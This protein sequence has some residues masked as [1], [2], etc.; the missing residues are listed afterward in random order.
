[1]LRK[2]WLLFFIMACMLLVGCNKENKSINIDIN[3]VSKSL[4]ENIEFKD[5]LELLDSEI[6]KMFYEIPDNTEYVLYMGSGAT[7]EE[8]AIFKLAD[9][10]KVE[11]IIKNIK[12]HIENQILQFEDYNNE[13]IKK[14]ENYIL[15]VKD[16]YVVLCVT[17]DIENA[18]SQIDNYVK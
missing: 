2:K 12:A 7:A 4:V 8:L 6:V 13:E 5:S 10:Q 16:N 11:E 17:D 18:K 1:M 3:S 14:L 9:E 15:K